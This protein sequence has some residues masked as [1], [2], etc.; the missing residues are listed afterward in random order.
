M[1]ITSCFPSA[2]VVAQ[3]WKKHLAW[4]KGNCHILSFD[5]N[6]ITLSADKENNLPLEDF[7]GLLDGE[8]TL[9]TDLLLNI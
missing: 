1:L 6:C 2:T 9:V 5:L 3:I 8:A 7:E 4:A